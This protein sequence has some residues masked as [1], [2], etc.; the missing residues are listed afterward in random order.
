[1]SAISG[2]GDSV[3]RVIDSTGREFWRTWLV[4]LT[5]LVFALHSVSVFAPPAR[6]ALSPT[7]ILAQPQASHVDMVSHVDM[8]DCPDHKKPCHKHEHDSSNSCPMCRTLG[9]ALAGAA[10][11]DFIAGVHRRLIGR[12]VIASPTARPPEVRLQ[13][14]PPRGPPSFA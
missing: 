12:L 14:P 2:D 11:D 5:A 10:L 9:C 3:S 7:T 6:L 1:L 13:S 8:P 4:R